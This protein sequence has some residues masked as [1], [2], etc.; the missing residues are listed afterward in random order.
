MMQTAFIVRPFGLKDVVLDG[1]KAS[2]D[3]DKVEEI[4]IRPALAALNLEGGTTT[5]IVEQGNIREDMFRLLV[6]ADI[7]VADLSIHNANVFYELGIRHGLRESATFLLRANIDKYPFDLATDRYLVYDHRNPAAA[8]QE[9]TR[10]LTATLIANRVDSPVYQVLPSLSPPDPSVLHVVPRDFV[11]AAER[12]R[13]SRSRGD[14][15]LLAHEART[16]HWAVEGLRTV[17][18]GQFNLRAYR[19]AKETFEWLLEHRPED[20]EANQKL[21]TIYQRLS[22]QEEPKLQADYLTRSSQAIQRVIDAEGTTRRDRAEAHA[23][24]GRNIKARWVQTFTGKPPDA[25]RVAALRSPSLTEALRGYALGFQQDL[26]HFYSGI[27]AMALLRIRIDLAQALGDVWL[28]QFDTEDDARR[29]LVAAE[30]QCEQLSGAV[31]LSLQASRHA[32]QKQSNPD[33]DEQLSTAISEADHALLTGQRPRTVAQRY[34]E[35]LTGAPAYAVSAVREQLAIFEQLQVRP[36]FVKEVRAAVDE[37]AT[38]LAPDT[39][40]IVG[41]ISRV[42]LFTGHMVDRE[43]RATPRFPRTPAA[44][45]EAR[46]L[47]ADA[48]AK[49][50]E[51]E[52]GLMI[53]VAGGACGGDILF[54]EVCAEMKIDTRMFLALPKEGFSA[55]SVQHGGA[56]W[57]DRYERLVDRLKPRI[58]AESEELPLWLQGREYTIWQRNN[59]WMLFNA[60]AMNSRSLTLIALWDQGTADGPG[61]TR[62]LVSQ[63]QSRGYK[64]VRLEAERLKAL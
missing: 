60:L 29:E 37:I 41:R 33:P 55:K 44:Q 20:V 39:T 25:A 34:R 19:G 16:F 47:I 31:A 62:D 24:H 18:R 9:L 35:A 51:N 28:D 12:A 6:T 8:L 27:N 43:G 5:E 7:V 57:V 46:R 3:F 52:S 61:G 49:E 36:E 17:G 45:A 38:T 53:G 64:V 54:H 4:L 21:A 59:L 22:E 56:E 10:A 40:A 1:A 26:N 30:G 48:V 42:L 14:L 58:L 11:E 63:M 23:L 50:R 15:R 2:I 13:A 32:L